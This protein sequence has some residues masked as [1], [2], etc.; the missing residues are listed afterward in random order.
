MD[1][2]RRDNDSR[3]EVFRESK[4]ARQIKTAR[5]EGG[6]ALEDI[7]WDKMPQ[8]SAS[9]HDGEESTEH[10]GD[11]DDEYGGDTEAEEGVGTTAISTVEIVTAVWRRCG[12][13]SVGG[14]GA[15]ARHR[16]S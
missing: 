4:A 14:S 1:E 16:S 10:G 12:R 11:H 5:K 3:T 6:N 13:R 8:A 2:C 15:C 9:R 7:V